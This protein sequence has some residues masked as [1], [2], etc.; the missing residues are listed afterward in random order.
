MATSKFDLPTVTMTEKKVSMSISRFKGAKASKK[1]KF[2][3]QDIDIVKLTVSQA[4][5]VQ[6]VV[7]LAEGDDNPDANLNILLTVLKFGAPDL[8]D[9]TLDD[10]KEF[11]MQDLTLLSSEIMKHSGMTPE[12]IK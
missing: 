5:Q 7:K 8:V 11:P 4:L 10:L 2:V 6:D 3:G 9:M 1:T 12:Q